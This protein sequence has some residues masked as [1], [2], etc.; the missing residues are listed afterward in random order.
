MEVNGR[1][2]GRHVH[3][4]IDTLH[5]TIGLLPAEAQ[6]T[7]RRLQSTAGEQPRLTETIASLI[8]QTVTL[9]DTQQLADCIDRLYCENGIQPSQVVSLTLLMLSEDEF[10]K[11]PAVDREK[12][13]GF[14]QSLAVIGA[15][16]NLQA[17]WAA[18]ATGALAKSLAEKGT[19]CSITMRELITDVAICFGGEVIDTASMA[20]GPR[21]MSFTPELV[22]TS[23]SD[24]GETFL[25]AVA[26]KIEAADLVEE[27]MVN[28]VAAL[29]GEAV[30]NLICRKKAP[31]VTQRLLS[32]DPLK[33]DYTID[34]IL[35]SGTIVQYIRELGSVDSRIVGH[36]GGFLAENLI[37]SFSERDR[38]LQYINSKGLMETIVGSSCTELKTIDLSTNQAA[39]NY[40]VTDVP[41]VVIPDWPP[42]DDAAERFLA[43]RVEERIRRYNLTPG[44]PLIVSINLPG[45]EPANGKSDTEV[46]GEARTRLATARKAVEVAWFLK[47]PS[48]FVALIFVPG[49]SEDEGMRLVQRVAAEVHHHHIATRVLYANSPDLGKRKQGFSDGDLISWTATGERQLSAKLQSLIHHR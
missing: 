37:A 18:R 39:I 9:S 28:L 24:S 38:D 31:Q 40:D 5:T 16:P 10:P 29:I 19:I 44:T 26:K 13:S 1:Y 2:N 45:T 27:T 22:V 3:A 4:A 47:K 42:I 48:D 12:L 17:A 36:L 33:Q 35:L 32:S 30:A 20:I 7:V 34:Q 8:T 43:T 49:R 46:V 21:L 11:W 25:D 14:G 41:L 6:L 23:I 15:R